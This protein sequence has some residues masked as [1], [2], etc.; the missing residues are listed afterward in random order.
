MKHSGNTTASPPTAIPEGTRIYAVGDIHGEVA[1]LEELFQ[2]IL[3]DSATASG[4][5][6]LLVFLGDY[7]DRGP[8]SRQVIDTILKR[9]PKGFTSVPL[10]GNH[11]WMMLRFLEEPDSGASWLWNGGLMT[12]ES[13]LGGDEPLMEH[14]LPHLSRALALALPP[15]HLSFLKGLRASYEVG[16]TL[17]TH[18]GIRPGVPLAEQSPTDMMWIREPFLSSDLDFGRV[19]VHGHTVVARPEVHF[20]RIALDTGAHASGR[21]TCLVLE[22]G[23]LRFIHT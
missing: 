5:R 4:M 1:L 19:V 9:T 23:G 7:V 13:Y 21:L 6:K 18:A 20:N 15:A 14:G 17:F 22:G 3:A 8:A 16:G 2:M 11:E 10:M 12:L